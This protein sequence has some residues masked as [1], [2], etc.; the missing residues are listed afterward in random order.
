M[1][2]VRLGGVLRSAEYFV[3]ASTPLESICVNS[4]IFVVDVHPESNAA[5]PE[6]ALKS[7]Y[8]SAHDGT[9]LG[10]AWRTAST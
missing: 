9:V 5:V 2:E 7:V 8:L 10:E 4:G 1:K 3:G 6:C